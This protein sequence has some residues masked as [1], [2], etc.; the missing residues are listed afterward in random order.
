MNITQIKP[1]PGKVIVKVLPDDTRTLSGIILPRNLPINQQHEYVEVISI[2]KDISN[3]MNL[4]I[5]VSPGDKCIVLGRG[6]YDSV[7]VNNQKY[8]IVNP[9]DIVAVIS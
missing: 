5:T 7:T 2:G 9:A 6:I 4:K 1:M 8:Y 3:E